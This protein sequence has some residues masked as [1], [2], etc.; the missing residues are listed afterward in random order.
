VTNSPPDELNDLALRLGGE[1][2]TSGFRPDAPNRDNQQDHAV[3]PLPTYEPFAVVLAALPFFD[4]YYGEDRDRIA[5][6]WAYAA[7]ADGE[8]DGLWADFWDRL[9]APV[10]TYTAVANLLNFDCE[11]DVVPLTD[12][13]EIRLRSFRDLSEILGWSRAQLQNTLGSDFFAGFGVGRFVV[14]FQA[15]V[16]KAPENLV[17]ANTG[18]EVLAVRRLLQALRLVAPGDVNVGRLFNGRVRPVVPD[19]G[20]MSSG[21]T[22]ADRG[23]GAAYVLPQDYIPDL[24]AVYELGKRFEDR[25]AA[26]PQISTALGRLFAVYDRALWSLPDRIVDDFVGLEALVGSNDEL[27][28]KVAMRVSGLLAESDPDR[29]AAFRRMKSFYDTRSKIVHGGALKPK[30]LADLQAE[31]ELRGFLRQLLLGFLRLTEGLPQWQPRGKFADEQLD[32]ILLD[33]KRRAALREAMG[34]LPARAMTVASGQGQI[35]LWADEDP[36]R[37]AAP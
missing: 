9:R 4:G 18:N 11:S 34:A 8:L 2:R 13:L 27:A 37:V 20:T 3:R 24:R 25:A 33:S 21:W 17:L 31:P 10:W 36:T 5:T 12:G 26:Y 30:H 35:A 32:E 14:V 16:A 23:P 7:T 6:S 15:T 19:L 22:S 29:L 1:A 28:F